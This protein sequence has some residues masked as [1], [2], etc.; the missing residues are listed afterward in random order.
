MTSQIELSFEDFKSEDFYTPNASQEFKRNVLLSFTNESNKRNDII[1]L[2]ELLNDNITSL[3]S[4]LSDKSHILNIFENR[5][6][7]LQYT[8]LLIYGGFIDLADEQL[9]KTYKYHIDKIE[10]GLKFSDPDVGRIIERL[11]AFIKTTQK[12]SKRSFFNPYERN[13]QI[14]PSQN[15]IFEFSKTI[16]FET[17]RF[18]TSRVYIDKY[19]INSDGDVLI[20]VDGKRVIKFNSKA[21]IVFEKV[22]EIK[23]G[24]DKLASGYPSGMLN[25]TGDFYINNYIITRDNRF[26]ELFLPIE[27]LKKNKLQLPNIGCLAY[28]HKENKYLVFYKHSLLTFNRDGQLEKTVTVEQVY[29]ENIITEK[30]WVVTQKRDKAI[31]IFDFSGK[32][33][34]TYEYGNGNNYCEFS[35]KHE[36][37]L[38]FSYST[39]SQLYNLTNGKKETLW[40]HPTF[41]KGYIEKMYNDTYHNFG[42]TIAKFSPDDS[43]IVGGGDH[44]KYAAWTLSKLN[45]VELIPQKEVIEQFKPHIMTSSSDQ[46]DRIEIV[47][48]AE[49][50]VLD[51][52][53]F[54]KNRY[55]GISKII[56]LEDGEF[57]LTVLGEEFILLWDKDFN[58][59]AFKR[60]KGRIN[61]HSEKYLTQRTK[62]ELIVYLQK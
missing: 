50:V 14:L 29:G 52:Q 9:D 6:Y 58:N 2:N 7:P 60:I 11:E 37:L 28:W 12:V 20:F 22:I 32:L 13:I 25:E 17:L 56:F 18:D 33:I 45:R 3:I 57:F 35:H 44:G 51:N 53:T 41:I 38:C 59:L 47:T 15:D 46:G 23:S 36:Y 30:E 5:E 48:K 4:N 39:K 8:W 27:K 62:D 21:E 54:L 1:S 24:F 34:G 40:A 42:M 31:V 49:L 19:H 43:Y 55:H 26:I 16:F 61:Y 10:E